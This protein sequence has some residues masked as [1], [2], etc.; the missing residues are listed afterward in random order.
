MVPSDLTQ[1]FGTLSIGFLAS[2]GVVVLVWVWRGSFGDLAAWRAESVW[3]PFETVHASLLVIFVILI[4]AFGL[5][6][7]DISDHLTDREST[8]I[9]ETDVLNY[10]WFPYWQV[11]VLRPAQD[12]IFDDLFRRER[13]GYRLTGLGRAMFRHPHYVETTA[14]LYE[15]E[16]GYFDALLEDPEAYLNAAGEREQ[17]LGVAKR[18][19]RA[20]YYPAKNWAYLQPTYFEELQAI[21]RRIDFSRTCFMVVS[22]FLFVMLLLVVF[23]CIRSRR[24][25]DRGARLR[26]EFD[27]V[28]VVAGVALALCLLTRL[29]YAYAQTNF[30]RRAIG[31]YVSYLDQDQASPSS[32]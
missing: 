27:R 20:S 9:F 16:P 4:Y 6:V 7:E 25:S 5:I 15:P 2:V 17:R 31:Y 14:R 13:D 8:E 3:K 12:Y 24:T 29:G 22:W 26:R 1:I 21:Q 30:D 28:A 11:R 10:A 23:R 19:A 18:F 32:D